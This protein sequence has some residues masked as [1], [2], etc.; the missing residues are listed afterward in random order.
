M[1]I[2][3]LALLVFAVACQP[4]TL[5]LNVPFAAVNWS[6]ADGTSGVCPTWPA[7]VCFN[8]PVDPGS[9]GNFLIGQSAD[10][11]AGAPIASG[12]TVNASVE[13]GDQAED[14]GSPNCVVLTPPA[15]GLQED[16]CYT[17]EV[18][19]EDLHPG[20]G[21]AGVLP[22]GGAAVLPVTLRS[23]FKVAP[24][25]EGCIAASP[26]RDGGS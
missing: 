15:S 7:T 16:A 20:S 8:E 4:P 26:S 2:A 13:R 1:K 12:G 10:C 18:E 24:S 22:D 23:I 6:P 11:D 21:A 19:G 9:L 3:P 25:T 17:I 14:G 5:E